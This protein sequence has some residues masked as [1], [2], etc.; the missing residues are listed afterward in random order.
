MADR[1]YHFIPASKP[2]LFDRAATLGAD[3]YIFDLE[4][5]VAADQKAAA[6][7]DLRAWLEGNSPKFRIMVRVNHPQ[8]PL[9]DQEQALLSDF[10]RLGVVLPKVESA[11]QM[12]DWVRFYT[13]NSGSREVMALIESAAGLREIDDILAAGL[14]HAV[15]LGLEDFMVQAFGCASELGDLVRHVRCRLG[16]AA[17]EHG[18]PAIDSISLDL[19]GDGTLPEELAAARSAGLTAKFSIHPHQIDPINRSF[20]P[21]AEMLALAAK[22]SG[23]LKTDQRGYLRLGGEIVSPPKIKRLQRL[24]KY[25]QSHEFIQ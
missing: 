7:C 22:L 20:S 6:I 3:C 5:A 2:I 19:R 16:V 23:Q 12:K 14:L 17:M 10:P 13:G 4:D 18:I 15:G 1:S 25:L 11:S 9:A 21:S 24:Q 8:H